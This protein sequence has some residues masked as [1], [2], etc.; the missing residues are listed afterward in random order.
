MNMSS[1]SSL[2]IKL[3]VYYRLSN[4]FNYI[5]KYLKLLFTKKKK[6]CSIEI[7]G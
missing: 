1:D 7:A 2:S 4:I 5:R 6:N 3:S